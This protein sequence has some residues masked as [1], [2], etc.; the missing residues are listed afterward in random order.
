MRDK[1]SENINF[2]DPSDNSGE[3]KSLA[4]LYSHPTHPPLFNR[5]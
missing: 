5:L 3:A 4:E 2:G 1:S